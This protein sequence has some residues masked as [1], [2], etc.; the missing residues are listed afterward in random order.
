[1]F[2]LSPDTPLSNSSGHTHA[3]V[4][5]SLPESYQPMGKAA[6][7]PKH[8]LSQSVAAH[9]GVSSL[10]KLWETGTFV[11]ENWTGERAPGTTAEGAGLLWNIKTRRVVNFTLLTGCFKCS[12]DS[13]SND[14]TQ[15]LKMERVHCWDSHVWKLGWLWV[16]ECGIFIPGGQAVSA[17]HDGIQW[18]WGGWQCPFKTQ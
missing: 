8:H 11:H 13:E 12:R 1:M 2:V 16:P 5:P 17:K 14:S 9:F 10:C 15:M 7:H 6:G 4:P 18:G 3:I